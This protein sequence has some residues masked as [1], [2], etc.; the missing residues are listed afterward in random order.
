MN[1]VG[2]GEQVEVQCEPH[3][4]LRGAYMLTCLETGQWDQE[5]PQC[6]ALCTSPPPTIPNSRPVLVSGPKARYSCLPG[7]VMV[8]SPLVSDLHNKNI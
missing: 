3:W 4:E 7:F 6:L 8:G 5:L 1:E 2:V